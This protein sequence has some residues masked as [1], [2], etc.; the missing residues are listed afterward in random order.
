M[1][2]AARHSDVVLSYEGGIRKDGSDFATVARRGAMRWELRTKGNAG[3]SGGIFSEGTGDGAIFE[4]SRIL[5][6]F[7]DELR[8]PNMTF[9]PGLALGGAN[10]QVNADGAASVS[11][12]DN[13][14]P[15]EAA[16]FGDLRALSIDQVQRIEAKMQAIVAASLPGTSATITFNDGYPP[17]APTPGNLALLGELN[18]VNR[19]LGEPAMAALDPMQRGAGDA[20]FV[21]PVVDVLDGLG[22][23][24]AGAHAP[25][26][27]ADLTR[28]PLQT[29]RTALLIDRLTHEP[30]P[31][32]S[33][34]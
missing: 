30:A 33:G 18:A 19:L 23:V 27:T 8:E 2:E 13:I 29:R 4:L 32:N 24:G 16:A 9:S 11:G 1:I 10:I 20:S 5:S 14:V 12:K 31:Q 15:G 17:M 3:H 26:E 28:L 34:R 22:A 6:R 7:H 21:A 25:G